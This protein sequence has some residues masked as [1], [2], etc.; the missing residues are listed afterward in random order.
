[1]YSSIQLRLLVPRYSMEALARRERELLEMDEALERRQQQA[2]ADADETLQSQEDRLNAVLGRTP[3]HLALG[4]FAVESKSGARSDLTSPEEH[5]GNG[6]EVPRPALKSV[7]RK[8][9]ND[10]PPVPSKENKS[11]THSNNNNN[12]APL[13]RKRNNQAE[14][15]SNAGDTMERI[16][17][18]KEL[19]SDTVIR[20]QRAKLKAL[21]EEL[22]AAKDRAKTI[23]DEHLAY[24]KKSNKLSEENSKL[25]KRCTVLENARDKSR[26]EVNT[27]R[28]RNKELENQ[29]ASLNREIKEST[30]ATKAVESAG[31]NKDV[32]LHRALEE[33]ERTKAKLRKHEEE[34]KSSVQGIEA[35]YKRVQAENKRLERQKTELLSAFRKQLKLIEVLKR[36]KIHLEAAKLLSFT[37]E[38]FTR[39]LDTQH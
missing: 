1:L 31:N 18:P 30:R 28:D 3:Q 15:G 38:E 21:A 20:L 37:E 17:S 29:V 39:T 23:Q 32:R 14:S 27:L 25:E 24:K 35:D 33:V 26:N 11:K 7:K 22:E 34:A 13:D 19:S 6:G 16:S 4:K 2:M 8:P 9:R 12:A 10:A 36:Q 5:R